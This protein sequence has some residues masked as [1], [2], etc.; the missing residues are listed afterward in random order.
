[1]TPRAK[2]TPQP[3]GIMALH[4]GVIRSTLKRKKTKTKQKQQRE[5]IS[6]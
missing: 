3:K 2:R 1:M 6:S 4:A 5:N